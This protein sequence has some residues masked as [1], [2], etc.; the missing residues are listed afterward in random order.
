MLED[1]A[2]DD[3]V[4]V[5]LAC[6]GDADAAEI[7]EVTVAAPTV[8]GDPPIV[9][10]TLDLADGFAPAAA[11][12]SS[13]GEVG[14]PGEGVPAPPVGFGVG[15]GDLAQTI[16]GPPALVY[17][18]TASQPCRTV[19]RITCVFKSI[20]SIKCYVHPGCSI[21]MAEWKLPCNEAIK[22]WIA[23]AQPVPPTA[24]AAAKAD[25][26]KSLCQAMKE[27][28]AAAVWPGRSRQV[29]IDSAA[30]SLPPL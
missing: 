11:S 19:C 20:P 3:A 25:D 17:F 1:F 30:S 27:L 9:S 13:A 12:S 4:E 21:A 10:S 15:P 2:A 5:V 16:I 6:F 18:L 26:V 8:D 24:T 28:A 23:G 14:A 22:A 7:P 29:L